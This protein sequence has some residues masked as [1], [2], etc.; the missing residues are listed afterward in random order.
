MI[1]FEKMPLLYQ[2][3]A[4]DWKETT[5]FCPLAPKKLLRGFAPKVTIFMSKKLPILVTGIPVVEMEDGK[6][7]QFMFKYGDDLRQDNLVL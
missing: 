1:E 7:F 4:I 3:E 6:K 2:N 5:I